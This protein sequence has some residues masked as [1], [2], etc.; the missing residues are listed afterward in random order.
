MEPKCEQCIRIFAAAL[1]FVSACPYPHNEE[2]PYRSKISHEHTHQELYAGPPVENPTTVIASTADAIISP[3]VIS[4]GPD[5]DID[6]NT[7]YTVDVTA[8][9]TT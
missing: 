7:V 8:S 9:P 4:S 2:C 3:Y 5:P 1:I 6:G